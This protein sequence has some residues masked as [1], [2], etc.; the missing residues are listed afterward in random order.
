MWLKH[1]GG[2]SKRFYVLLACRP[3]ELSMQFKIDSVA[4]VL[5]NIQ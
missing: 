2:E 1:K 3:K 4:L 5:A